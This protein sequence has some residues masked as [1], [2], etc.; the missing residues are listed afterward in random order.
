MGFWDTAGKIANA[1]GEA[2]L[3]K[4]KEIEQ[5]YRSK[6]RSLTDAQ[7]LHATKNAENDFVKNIA[8]EEAQRRGL[9]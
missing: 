4:Q 5:R 2:L 9:L 7:L 8:I 3:Q 6:A 1:A